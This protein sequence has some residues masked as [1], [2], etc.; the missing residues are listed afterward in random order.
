MWLYLV[1][2]GDAAARADWTD[3]DAARPLTK[4]GQEE[5]RA[6]A[7]GLASLGLKVE[8]LLASPRLRADQ[9]AR[10]IAEALHAEVTTRDELSGGFDVAA[11]G[12]LLPEFASASGVMIVGHEPDLSELAGT[13]CANDHSPARLH[14]RKAACCALK[15]PRH[16]V[17]TPGKHGADL[18]GAAT[19]EWFLTAPHL[20]QIG[21]A[22][23]QSATPPII[24][25]GDEHDADGASANDGT[26]SAATTARHRTAMNGATPA[27][28]DATSTSTRARRSRPQTPAESDTGDATP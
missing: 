2:H 11:L 28:R 1:R 25:P 10:L 12:T 7:R 4:E 27:Q 16:L 18:V 14:M 13:L 26:P 22:G 23:E 20:A 24:A 8:A 19:L 9:T 17:E 6:A 5:V 21:T 3:D 15:L